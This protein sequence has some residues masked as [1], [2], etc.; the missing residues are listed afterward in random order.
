[1]HERLGVAYAERGPMTDEYLRVILELWTS[2]RPQFKGRYV[3][4]DLVHAEPRPVQQPHPPIL[5]GGYG[6]RAIL[7][8]VALGL[9][10]SGP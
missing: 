5:I 10:P 4:F 2:D 6:K 8:A 9:M 1:V 3:N 7:R